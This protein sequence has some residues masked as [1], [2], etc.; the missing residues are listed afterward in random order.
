MILFFLIVFLFPF[1]DSHFCC[2]VSENSYYSKTK[3]RKTIFFS[4]KITIFAAEIELRTQDIFKQN[5][6]HTD[7]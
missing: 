4:Q 2:K 1:S 3:T 6:K 7:T 5:R